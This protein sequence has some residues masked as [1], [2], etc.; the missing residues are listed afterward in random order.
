MTEWMGLGWAAVL[1]VA[2]CACWFVWMWL[3]RL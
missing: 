3:R 1:L 2:V